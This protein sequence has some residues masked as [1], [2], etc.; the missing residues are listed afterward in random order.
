MNQGYT[1]NQNFYIINGNNKILKFGVYSFCFCSK[2]SDLKNKIKNELGL[3][4]ECQ[5]LSYKERILQ[6]SESIIDIVLEEDIE[7][8]LKVI[9]PKFRDSWIFY[10]LFNIIF[11]IWIN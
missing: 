8:Q 5:E 7:L 9:N 10:I 4:V 3:N 1:F 11:E 6:D 2:I